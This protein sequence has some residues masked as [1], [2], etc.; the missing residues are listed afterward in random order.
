MKYLWKSEHIDIR[1]S[2]NFEI[3]YYE[4]NLVKKFQRDENTIQSFKVM[5]YRNQIDEDTIKIFKIL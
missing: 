5:I 1:F 4:M 2:I 3:R